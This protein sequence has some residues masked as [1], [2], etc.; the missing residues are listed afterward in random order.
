[1]NGQFGLVPKIIDLNTQLV[2]GGNYYVVANVVLTLP[3][4]PRSGE[5]VIISLAPNVVANVVRSGTST[6]SADGLSDTD[7][8][9]VSATTYQFIARGAVWEVVYDN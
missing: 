1:M 8:N 7:V 6:I 9:L 2:S 5:S 4:A 3:V